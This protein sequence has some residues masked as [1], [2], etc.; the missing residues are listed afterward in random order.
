MEFNLKNSCNYLL[1][2]IIGSLLPSLAG[3]E[4][5]AAAVV[6]N[7]T[8]APVDTAAAAPLLPDA[9]WLIALALVALVAITRRK[10]K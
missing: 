3:A 4:P 1:C 5:A 7:D 9:I 6:S 2:W 8:G 10:L